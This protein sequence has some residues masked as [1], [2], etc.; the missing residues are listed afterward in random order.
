M[1][2]QGR[3]AAMRKVSMGTRAELVA[4]THGRY[5]GASRPEKRRILDEFVAVTG[6]HRKH[7]MRLLRTGSQVSKLEGRSG[8][9][10]MARRCVRRLS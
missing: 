1:V 3:D 7:A 6:F 9:G 5:A 8:V 4:A 10:S 2:L